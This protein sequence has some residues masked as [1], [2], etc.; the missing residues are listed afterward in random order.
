[1]RTLW[2]TGVALATFLGGP[3]LAADMPV[4]PP[5]AAPVYRPALAPVYTWTGCYVGVQGGWA[6]G[7]SR[8]DSTAATAITHEFSIDGGL[9]GGTLGC[10]YQIGLFV[11]GVEGDYSWVG[12]KG[13]GNDH[14]PP[15]SATAISHTRE[16]ALWTARIR[17]GFAPDDRWL[18]YVTGGYAGATV[19]ARVVDT[20]LGIDFSESKTRSGWTAGLGV[21]WVFW[22]NWSA[23]AE[24]LYVGLNNA[25]YFDGA[26]IGIAA[27]S[28]VLVVDN[29]IRAGINYRFG[30]WDTPVMARY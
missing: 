15:F 12:K 16:S 13:E 11:V 14:L 10:N 17:L 30:P 3:A 4:R 6:F 28:N 8:H 27:R 25:S 23:K 9:A 29:V 26:P 24:Y 21:E 19:E 7:H 5:V 20:P 1:M 2:S 18:V 22:G